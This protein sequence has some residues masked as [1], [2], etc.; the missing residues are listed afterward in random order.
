M[1]VVGYRTVNTEGAGGKMQPVFARSVDPIPT[2]RADYAYQVTIRP[3]GFSDL[4]T[5]LNWMGRE[6]RKKKRRCKLLSALCT[7]Q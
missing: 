7:K 1:M 4:P 2:K 5:A 3:H 6:P